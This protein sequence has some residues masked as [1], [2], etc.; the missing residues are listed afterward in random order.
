[1]QQVQLV[2]LHTRLKEGT[3][4]HYEKMHRRV[5]D[6]LAATMVAGGT[7]E[8]RIWRDGRD[9]FHWVLVDDWHALLEHLA[10]DPVDQAWQMEVGQILDLNLPPGSDGMHHVWDLSSQINT[11]TGEIL[12]DTAAQD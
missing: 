6:E 12:P 4:E 2:T 9:L 11:T 5:R 10:N 1:M 7:R 3:E 8:W